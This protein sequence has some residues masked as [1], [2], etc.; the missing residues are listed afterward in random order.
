MHE[1]CQPYLGQEGFFMRRYLLAAVAAA[2][3]ASPA[4]ARD[5][6]GYAGVDAGVL[7]ADN[8]DFDFEDS[9]T[10]INNVVRLNHDSYGFDLG[11][12]GGYDFG[13][14]RVEGEL[15]YKHV[16]VDEIRLS[17]QIAN[18]AD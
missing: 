12:F 17:P 5:H 7:H 4:I 15:A 6:S 13:M 11:L 14:F 9:D 2:A 10:L 1:R 8:I 3:I 18:S 16:S